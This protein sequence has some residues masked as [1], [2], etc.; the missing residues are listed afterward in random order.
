[1]SLIDRFLARIIRQGTL[2]L[3][4]HQGR[5]RSF[6]TAA[7]GF[8]DVAIRL[9]DKHVASF[10]ALHPRLGAGEAYMDGRLIIERGDIM[11]L[12]QLVRAN[13]P[14]DKGGELKPKG[15]LRKLV[16]AIGGRIDQINPAGRSQRNVAHHYDLDDRLYDL[17]LDADKQYS[18]AYFTDPGN[19]LQQA[20]DDKKAHI[21][22]KLALKPG[23]KVLDIG[24]G[25]GGMA[26]YLNRVADVDVLGIT[27]SHEQLK[28]ARRRA[29]EAGV[30]D[31]VKFELIDY[32]ALNGSFDRI[33]SVGMFEH[34]GVPQYETF[35][36]Q[37]R[38]LLAQNGVML[39][40]TIGRMGVPGATDAFTTKYI[41]PG[42]YIPALSEIVRASEPSR[43]IATDVET[44]R[45]HYAHTLRL[46]YQRTVEK[47][48][49]IEALYDA[50]FFRMWTFY[51]AG[52][53][54]AFEHGGM[55]NYQVQFARSRHALPITRDYMAEAEAQYRSG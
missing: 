29:E 17:F 3:T 36:R 52:A 53:T 30:A 47:R 15:P 2:E 18:C 51:L 38:K 23:L 14:W 54:A 49:E 50:R 7:P 11:Q 31:R 28:V 6:G 9:A 16:K 55:C 21:A 27:L 48:A 1:M 13:A 25:W 40:H 4:D 43:L 35:F 12:I 20:Q 22:A 26:L 46:W 33:V 42:G 39:L 41:F 37:C 44:L 45:L 24:C 8:P 19:S 10:I 5:T 32:R 34:V